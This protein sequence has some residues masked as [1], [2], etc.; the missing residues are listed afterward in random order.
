MD[1]V[2]YVASILGIITAIFS[3]LGWMQ[4]RRIHQELKRETERL[5][6]VVAV[7]LV[8]GGNEIKLPVELPRGELTRAELQG[9]L[10]LIPMKVKGS[11]YSLSY[12]SKPEFLREFDRIKKEDGVSVLIIPCEKDEFEQFDVKK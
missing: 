6:Q 2:G 10:G 5:S 1:T 9:R 4:S 7:K 3:F 11:R 8:Y 12:L